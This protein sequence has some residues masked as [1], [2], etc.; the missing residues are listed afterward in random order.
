M[1]QAKPLVILFAAHSLLVAT[2]GVASEGQPIEDQT[3]D[4]EREISEIDQEI[5]E[6]DRELADL[7]G[8]H[9]LEE[10]PVKNQ[11]RDLE[12]EISDLRRETRNLADDSF[13]GAVLFLFGAFCSLWAQRSGR[14]A[15]LWFFLGFFFNIVTVVVLLYK[16][17]RH[18]GRPF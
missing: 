15:W 6:I 2:L 13:D 10:S 4:L 14:N 17:S 11:L 5:S 1:P 12:R 16:N 7:G 3:R 8:A 9:P 18:E